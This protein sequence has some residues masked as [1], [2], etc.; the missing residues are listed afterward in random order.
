LIQRQLARLPG[1]SRG[2][3]QAPFV[4]L[5]GVNMPAAL[6]E[7]GFITNPAESERMGQRDRQDAIASALAAAISEAMVQNREARLAT[8]PPSPEEKP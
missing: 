1:P 8:E 3:K 7:I 4:V 2:V 6:V 5:T